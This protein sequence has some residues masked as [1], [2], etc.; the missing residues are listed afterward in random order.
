MPSTIAC[1]DVVNSK[2]IGRERESAVLNSGSVDRIRTTA[3]TTR[4]IFLPAAGHT[5]TMSGQAPGRN[6]ERRLV[7]R[8]RALNGL[9]PAAVV[10]NKP[11]AVVL[12][13]VRMFVCSLPSVHVGR[14]PRSPVRLSHPP[15]PS[16]IPACRVTQPRLP[17]FGCAVD[18]VGGH[19]FPTFSEWLRA[20]SAT[21]SSSPT[22][23][24]Q[25]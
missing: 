18:R 11:V 20:R 21:S 14:S 17:T 1:V 8:L 19:S 16:V 6:G 7:S 10:A 15:F 24:G 22:V 2:S 25:V 13:Y 12:A 23:P 9:Q 3:K 5:M 4:G